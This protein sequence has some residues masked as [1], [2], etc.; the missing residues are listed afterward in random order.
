MIKNIVF[1]I[2]KVLFAYEPEY[3]VDTLLP[4]TPH[5]ETH[6]NE[7]FFSPLWQQRDRGD[8]TE[9]EAKKAL[10]EAVQHHPEKRDEIHLLFDR[11]VH[12]LRVIEGSKNIFLKLKQN[13]PV[14]I[15]SNFQ[16]KAFD[17]LLALNPFLKEA[18]GFVVSG[19]LNMMKPEPEIY[20][21][22]LDSFNLI[23]SETLFID[24]LPE[25]IEGCRS[26]G[27]QG[28][29]FTSPE[30]TEAQLKHFGVLN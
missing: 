28:I 25:N 16:A 14:F 22:L 19:K 6:L 5:K 18:D 9:F 23:A 27:M 10:S 1:D 7:L 29:L 17:Q 15:L 12:H 13:Y 11:W 3:I 4:E 30:E 21:H 20:H 26:V 24:D 8:V 2:G